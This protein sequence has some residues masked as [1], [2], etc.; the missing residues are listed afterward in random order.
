MK[1]LTAIFPLTIIALVSSLLLSSCITIPI[2]QPEPT[3]TP[4][5]T[6]APEPTP[7]PAPEPTPDP[8]PDDPVETAPIENIIWVLESF[9]QSLP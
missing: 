9:A 5:P 6:P 8:Q 4:T 1:N 7:T 3:P 2:P